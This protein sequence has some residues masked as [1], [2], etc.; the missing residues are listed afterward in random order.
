M[1]AMHTPRDKCFDRMPSN[2]DKT[3]LYVKEVLVGGVDDMAKLA[4]EGDLKAKLAL[5]AGVHAGAN[6]STTAT[7]AGKSVQDRCKELIKRCAHHLRDSDVTAV[8]SERPV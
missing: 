3:Q 6:G 8:N 5:A 2:R 1:H 7:G 4:E